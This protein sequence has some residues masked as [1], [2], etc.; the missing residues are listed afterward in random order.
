MPT[1]LLWWDAVP[2]T[3][4]STRA[5]TDKTVAHLVNGAAL[6][7][8]LDPERDLGTGCAPGLVGVIRQTSHKSTDITYSYLQLAELLRSGPKRYMTVLQEVDMTGIV[9]VVIPVE[10]EAAAALTDTRKRE[11]VGRIVS[12]ILRPLPDHD[13]LLEAMERLITDATAKGLTPETLEAELAA[14]K[15]ER[16]R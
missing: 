5:L 12:R 13:P 14:H 2:R 6:A 3:S 9:E 15:A 11:A 16:T 10:A 1:P 7:A 8:S 4:P